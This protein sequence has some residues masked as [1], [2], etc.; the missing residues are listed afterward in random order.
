MAHLFFSLLGAILTV[1]A[2]VLA[3][4]P[5]LIVVLSIWIGSTLG[6]VVSSTLIA[7]SR[8]TFENK[9]IRGMKQSIPLEG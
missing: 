5:A 8:M 4:Q 9:V 3:G 1:I 7:C 6:L 2:S